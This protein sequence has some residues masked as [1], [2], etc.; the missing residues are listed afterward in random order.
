MEKT[1]KKYIQ[2]ILKYVI[3]FFK[4][5]F[6]VNGLILVLAVILSFTDVPY[7]AYYQLG[8]K[9]HNLSK[10][11]DYIVL[12]GGG[13]MPCPEGFMRIYYAA[14]FA[15]QY[16]DAAIIVAMPVVDSAVGE[17]SASQ[18]F[19][20][21]LILRGVDSTRISLET[22]G[23]NTFQQIQNICFSLCSVSHTVGISVVTSPEH[24][25][26]SIL[27][28]N[29]LGYKNVGGNAA[30]ENVESEQTFIDKKNKEVSSNLSLRYNMW[31]YLKYELI[32]VREYCALG[33]YKFRGWI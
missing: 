26:R 24:M 30:F 14:E 12:L 15:H 9:G 17:N 19:L 5:F 13:G 21:E 25:Y 20:K 11:P 29:K 31:N 6:I 2:G 7:F 18:K 28:F 32:V 8:T 23:V 27:C 16:P 4:Y 22:R 3:S 10:K 1:L 33:Y